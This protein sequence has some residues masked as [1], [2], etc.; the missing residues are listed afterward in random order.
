MAELFSSNPDQGQAQAQ[1]DTQSQP[2][3][4]TQ[5]GQS[6]PQA[7]PQSQPQPSQQQQ[8]N[9]KPTVDK[10]TGR[11]EYSKIYYFRYT[12]IDLNKVHIYD[13]YP[14]VIFLDI[15]GNTALGIN[16]HWIPGALRYKFVQVIIEMRK[17]SINQSLFRLWYNVIKYNPSLNF[18]LQAIRRYYIGHCTNI[19]VIE[20]WEMIPYT[21]ILYKARY[22]QR[23]T[24]NPAAHIVQKGA[25]VRP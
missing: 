6:Q 8:S 4:Q 5:Q 16:L 14:Q 18:S 22:L 20:A 7:Q 9:I 1:G 17:K 24:Y 21:Q 23:S 2:Q 25:R 12:P 3:G 10:Y 13:Q 19:K 11:F 15:R